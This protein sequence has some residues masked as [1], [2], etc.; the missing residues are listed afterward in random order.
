MTVGLRKRES[1]AAFELRGAWA[2]RK[3]VSLLLD[4][5]LADIPRIRGTVE[6]VA[7]TDAFCVVLEPDG[8][9][10]HVPLCAV[11]AVRSP[12]FHEP[13]DEPARTDADAPL[14]GQTRIG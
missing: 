6:R 12:H 10:T 14:P 7:A 2:S 9:P 11:L 1:A 13:A 8:F 5:D 3:V 4:R